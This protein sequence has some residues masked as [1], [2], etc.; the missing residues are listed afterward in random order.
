MKLISLG[1]TSRHTKKKTAEQIDHNQIV[2]H[3]PDCIL[4]QEAADASCHMENCT[5]LHG[6]TF[7]TTGSSQ[8][9]KCVAQRSWRVIQ[10]LIPTHHHLI[11]PA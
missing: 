8:M 5:Q 6:S 2:S 11:E 3:Q 4:S 7:S 10:N 1:A 9:L